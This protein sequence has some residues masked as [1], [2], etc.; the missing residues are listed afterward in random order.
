M[1]LLQELDALGSGHEDHE[2]DVLAAP[3]LHFADGLCGAAAGSQHGVHD[4]HVALGNVL[5]HFAEIG[6]GL[7]SLLVPV[8]TDMAH[9]GGGNHSQHAV[10]QTQTG[11]EDGDDYELAAGQSGGVHLADGGLNVLGG[12]GQ[13]AGG[14]IGDEH[15]D[16]A[17][18]FPE[19]LDA[20]VLVP[21]D[22]QLVGHQG[23]IHNDY[24]THNSVLLYIKKLKTLLNRRRFL[25]QGVRLRRSEVESLQ[26]LSGGQLALCG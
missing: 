14:L 4:Q 16:L 11:P 13:I 2:L 7:Q 17:D 19:I 12:H 5:G 22:G 15:T 23:M 20:G 21:H 3:L 25:F 18:Q 6:M 8:H 10:H 1:L 24:F 9:T 26:F